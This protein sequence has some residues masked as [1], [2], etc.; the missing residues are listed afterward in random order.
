MQKMRCFLFQYVIALKPVADT[1]DL[2]GEDFLRL[3]KLAS[4]GLMAGGL[5]HQI[6][7]RLHVIGLLADDLQDLLATK[8]D[9][10]FQPEV[11]V[12][13]EQLSTGLSRLAVHVAQGKDTVHGLMRYV[14][15][16]GSYVEE[17]SVSQLLSAAVDLAGYKHSLEGVQIIYEWICGDGI[18]IPG[19]FTQLQEVFFNI[20]DNA[21]SALLQKKEHC[22]T[23]GYVPV[24]RIRAAL[25][26]NKLELSF[27]DN[28]TGI[29]PEDQSIL[30]T[31]FFT[32][33]GEGKGTGLGLYVIRKIVEE[34]HN[35][36]VEIRSVFGEGTTVTLS[37]LT[38]EPPSF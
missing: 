14:R 27:S 3:E 17:C 2:P 7:N 18:K 34:N 13:H 23:K 19:F 5:A 24:L 11:K 8:N 25:C 12:F 36:S 35:G 38:G 20:I 9:F 15:Q 10:F 33:K 31:P 4:I 21:I 29:T 26:A 1:A 6:N 16:Q 30:F 32:T 22:R 28:G 37:L